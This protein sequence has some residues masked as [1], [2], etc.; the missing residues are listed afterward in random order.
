MNNLLDDAQIARGMDVMQEFYEDMNMSDVPL[1]V[2][3]S[4]MLYAYI[5]F[6]NRFAKEIAHFDT[7]LNRSAKRAKHLLQN[8][9]N[10]DGDQPCLPL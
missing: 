9:A 4:C 5:V 7:D 3:E 2:I 10:E 6:T 8:I 1:P